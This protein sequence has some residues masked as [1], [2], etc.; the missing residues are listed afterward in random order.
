MKKIGFTLIELLVVMAIITALCLLGIP[1][2][3]AVSKSFTDRSVSIIEQLELCLKE[4]RSLAMLN[5]CRAGLRFQQT[6]DN[7]QYAVFI[8]EDKTIEL[9]EEE[10]ENGS[11]AYV[12]VTHRAPIS[13]GKINGIM[14]IG[15]FEMQDLSDKRAAVIFRSDGRLCFANVL[16][17]NNPRAQDNIIFGEDGL[18]PEDI[19]QIV[20]GPCFVIYLQKDSENEGFWQSLRPICINR[21]T[22]SLIR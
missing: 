9:T 8:I 15:V 19:T 20:S 18:F 5:R 10:Q 16:M 22:G 2:I 12:A 1:A 14:D 17:R 3:R 7:I 4:T 13:L 6:Q 21:Y 11:S